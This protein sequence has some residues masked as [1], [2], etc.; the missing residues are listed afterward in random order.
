MINVTKEAAGWFKNELGVQEG[1]AIRFLRDIVP[2]EPFTR[3][4]RWASALKP[5]SRQVLSLR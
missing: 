4:L 3:D 5:R 1:Q 2:E